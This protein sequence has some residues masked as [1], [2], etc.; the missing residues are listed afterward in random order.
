MDK[1]FTYTE[2]VDLFKK[3]NEPIGKG[4]FGVVRP[5]NNTTL[6]KTYFADAKT[7]DATYILDKFSRVKKEENFKVKEYP[8]YMTREMRIRRA[9]KELFK[10]KYSGGLIKGIAYYD[11]YAFGTLLTWYKNYLT[12][13]SSEA[14]RLSSEEREKIIQNIDVVLNDFFDNYIYPLDLKES[15]IMYNP[16]TLDIKFIDLEDGLVHF[17]D[18][19]SSYEHDRCVEKRNQVK[20]RL[21]K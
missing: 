9:K 20:Q 17:R 10:T 13:S 7:D 19:Y 8:Y 1:I 12:L 21:L 16:R 3:E 5:L 18:S 15:N 4:I 2:L 14:R 11:G 6:I